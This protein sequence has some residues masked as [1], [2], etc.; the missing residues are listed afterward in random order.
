M[1]FLSPD[2]SNTLDRKLRRQ[3]SSVRRPRAVMYYTSG[4]ADYASAAG[5]IARAAGAFTEAAVLFSFCLTGDGWLEHNRSDPRWQSYR[6]WRASL[7]EVRRLYD[8]PGHLIE[9][10]EA[11]QL[12]RVIEFALVLGW[13]ALVTAKPERNLLFLSHDDRVDVMVGFEARSLAANLSKL[14]GWRS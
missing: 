9:R 3:F 10:G 8:A 11:E 5:L 14:R 4:Q 13:D 12:S 2:E 7:G 1:R 6:Q